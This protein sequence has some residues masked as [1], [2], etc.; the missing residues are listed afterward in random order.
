MLGN[1][2]PGGRTVSVSSKL[3]RP[4]ISTVPS[5]WCRKEYR[6]VSLLQSLA[7]AKD[8][9]RSFLQARGLVKKLFPVPRK[10][11][12]N[13][14]D[15]EFRKPT[16]IASFRAICAPDALGARKAVEIEVPLSKTL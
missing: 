11:T 3:L 8:V 1:Q 9:V 14:L 13:R 7:S 5:G 4:Q 15:I 10:A 16:R 6:A 12:P 2:G